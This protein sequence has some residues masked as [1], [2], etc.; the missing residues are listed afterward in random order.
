[1]QPQG[2]GASAVP[3]HCQQ[4]VGENRAREEMQEER[5]GGDEEVN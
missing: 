5:G 1:M 2:E 4:G 3:P